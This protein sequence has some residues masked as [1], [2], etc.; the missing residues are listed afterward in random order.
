MKAII[1][2]CMAVLVLAGA[3]QAAVV[4]ALGVDTNLGE[5]WRSTGVTK[6]SYAD[7]NGDKVYGS[8][9]YYVAGYTAGSSLPATGGVNPPILSS[10]PSYI[11]SVT[12]DV[13]LTRYFDSGYAALDDPTQSI[14][15][16][17]ANLSGTNPSPAA[18]NATGVWFFN[19]NHD[20]LTFQLAATSEFVLTVILD[21]GNSTASVTVSG[22]GG[23]T[24]TLAETSDGNPDYAFFDIQGAAGDIFT[25]ALTANN[26]HFVN[27]YST[28]S[29][30]GFEVVPEPASLSLLAAG[31]LLVFKR[32]KKA[33]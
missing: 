29:G 3:A 27:G 16:A 26:A 23:A 5:G 20:F 13:N 11:T 4:T 19:G 32:H 9:G 14:S 28:A 30:L 22:P 2:G 10:L 8:D 24:D 15:A 21:A 12:P 6:A 17:V 25:V 7:P 18:Q 33:A 31:G 1:L